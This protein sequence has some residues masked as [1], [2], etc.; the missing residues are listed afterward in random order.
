MFTKKILALALGIS[1]LSCALSPGAASKVAEP[2]L[3]ASKA[4]LT[5]RLS[6]TQKKLQELL[7][8]TPAKKAPVDAALG[9]LEKADSLLKQAASNRNLRKTLKDEIE[10]DEDVASSLP[11][12]ILG[13]QSAEVGA[14]LLQEVEPYFSPA[15]VQ[16][17]EIKKQEIYKAY[18]LTDDNVLDKGGAAALALAASKQLSDALFLFKILSEKCMEEVIPKRASVKSLRK[19]E[20]EQELAAGQL[21]SEVEAQYTE[22]AAQ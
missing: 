6:S 12:I 18:A 2:I 5:S 4:K 16:K 8:K 10:R 15:N 13:S 21:I 1:A 22:F 11:D 20:R 9:I 17:K 19:Q 14:K 3:N 7:L